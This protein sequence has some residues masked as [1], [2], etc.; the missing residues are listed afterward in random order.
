MFLQ[1]QRKIDKKIYLV[2][3]SAILFIVSLMYT[4]NDHAHA[5]VTPDFSP[6]AINNS[7]EAGIP[8]A[9]LLWDFEEHKYKSEDPML[10]EHE[11]SFPF[12]G[13]SVGLNLEKSNY[14]QCNLE[15]KI[16][17]KENNGTY[18]KWHDLSVNCCG[19]DYP[20]ELQWS[21]L[22]FTK[23]GHAHDQ[24]EIKIVPSPNK[25]LLQVK[26]NIAD[27]S[28]SS[29]ETPHTQ[30]DTNIQ[31]KTSKETSIEKLAATSTSSKNER[32][33]IVRR[34][35]WWGDMNKSK[36]RPSLNPIDPSHAVVH[37]TATEN[38]PSDPK[39]AIRQMWN[40][41][42]NSLGWFDIGYN[43]LIDEDGNIYEG[44]NNENMELF[45]VQGAHAGPQNNSSSIGVALIGQFQS[46]INNPSPGEP[47]SKAIDSLENLLA[48]RFTQYNID[49]LGTD[50]IGDYSDT[51]T[52]CGHRDV[53]NTSCPGN[54]LYEKLPQIREEV[55][56]K[57]EKFAN[58]HQLSFHPDP[59]E[60]GDITPY[61]NGNYYESGTEIKLE[62][63]ST[64][65]YLFEKWD[66]EGSHSNYPENTEEAK[67]KFKMPGQ[68]TKINA[69]FS[70]IEFEHI[71]R[72]AGSN[73]FQTAI[74]ISQ[75]AFPE[76][77][78]NDNNDVYND[79]KDENENNNIDNDNY[80][81][82]QEKESA[83][84]VILA[85]G[86]DF[87][88]ALTGVPL[89]YHKNAPLLLTPSNE[90]DEDTANE[91]ERVLEE[92]G[93]IYILGGEVAISDK[94]YQGLEE[95]YGYNLER[96]SGANR[97]E[98]ATCIAEKLIEDKNSSFPV[99]VAT[100]EDFPDAVAIS[101]VAAIEEGVI[102][103]TGSDS[104]PEETK[105]FLH[106]QENNLEQIYV[107]G[108][109]AAVSDKVFEKIGADKR[110]AGE[111]RWETATEIARKFFDRPQ[112]LTLATGLD[113]PDALTGGNFAA[114]KTAPVLLTRPDEKPEV[115]TKYLERDTFQTE[116]YAF[117]GTSAIN[118]KVITEIDEFLMDQHN[119]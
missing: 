24:F 45:D 68:K 62:A 90:L 60:G 105:T 44:R 65:E 86:D 111:N 84:A 43:F 61:I 81:D 97:Y 51:D 4:S 72:I 110:I 107:I 23:D 78:N 2:F 87:P 19:A 17:T 63:H 3:F 59:E 30:E 108:G 79:D 73:R 100:G 80:N 46:S 7:A 32:P 104:M 16:R 20:S 18:G 99:F 40:Y 69:L 42:V 71:T 49:P 47:E 58:F 83:E 52:I 41:H 106:N 64:N 92:N 48:W 25:E 21:E 37:H 118:R 75:K 77:E 57:M 85:R 38:S 5:T 33:R 96:I 74:E 35:E 27:A 93:T 28:D 109:K 115:L 15:I 82:E 26:V 70:P 22:F 34:E 56:S 76:K 8:S 53:G 31:N 117:G 36:K 101:S 1:A 14:C 54:K 55:N 39:Q 9:N 13:V 67:I 114:I 50:D 91:I 12:T 11:S 98:T 66:F 113:F 103:L 29:S 94:I 95:E 10:L 89:A 112:Y 119:R 6:E 102:L 88:D 116:V